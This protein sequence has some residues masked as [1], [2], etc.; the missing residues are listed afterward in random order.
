MSRKTLLVQQGWYILLTPSPWTIADGPTMKF[1]AN[2]NVLML[3]PEQK[4]QSID[5]HNI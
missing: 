4:M 1:V 5:K 3:E 2:I